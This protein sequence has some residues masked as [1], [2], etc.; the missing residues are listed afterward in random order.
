MAAPLAAL[1]LAVL[2]LGFTASPLFGVRSVIVRG[3][4]HLG[5]E[6]VI[7][8]ADLDSSANVYWFR[9]GTA[10]RLLRG[11]PW[12]AS[13]TVTGV[14]PHTVR[15]RLR[16]RRPVSR[17][18]VGSMWLLVAGDGTVLG[19]GGKH[20]PLPVLPAAGRLA[21]GRGDPNVAAA[22]RV[23]G[24]MSPWLRSR[25]SAVLPQGD[26]DIVLELAGG[27]RVLFG[28]AEELDAKDRALAGILRWAAW[29]RHSLE[30]VDLRAPL[31]P[32][33]RLG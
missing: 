9:A 29:R 27:G 18:Q 8:E 30:Y 28:P 15:I 11:N 4:D 13:A 17:V 19:P 12:V 3:N 20:R 7:R 21:V 26:G 14:L 16:E 6:E 24:R 1:G 25:I 32:A 10:E 5:R 23:A 33:A 22:A 31:A 2:G